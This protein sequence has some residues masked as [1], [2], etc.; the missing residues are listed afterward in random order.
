MTITSDVPFSHDSNVHLFARGEKVMP[1]GVNSPVR[2]FRAV[3]GNPVYFASGKAAQLHTV[4][5]RD[6]LD[7]CCSWGALLFGHAHPQIIEAVRQAASRGTSFGA[8]TTAEIELAERLTG[9]VPEAEMVR[10]VN[11][12]T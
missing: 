4:D 2:S 11:S 5:G 12:G 7:F 9:L 10:L 3:G 6:L 8:N 1:G